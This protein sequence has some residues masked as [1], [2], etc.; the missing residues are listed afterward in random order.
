MAAITYSSSTGV[1]L[2]VDGT[3]VGTYPTT[4]GYNGNLA[5]S[6]NM[7][8]YWRIGT[9]TMRDNWMCQGTGS[10]LSS[11][12]SLAPPGTTT[13]S[14]TFKGELGQAALFQTALSSS[15]ISTLYGYHA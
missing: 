5:G 15:V 8:G 1:I 12:C 6:D 14:P 9:G 4:G 13:V 10:T 11:P 2:Y 3:S 7:V